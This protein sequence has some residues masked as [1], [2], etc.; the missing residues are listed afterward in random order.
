[1]KRIAII[2]L[3]AL[4][5]GCATDQPDKKNHT[6]TRIGFL[7]ESVMQH[8]ISLPSLVETQSGKITIRQLEQFY[9]DIGERANPAYQIVVTYRPGMKIPSERGRKIEL[10]GTVS[11][12]DVGGPPGTK[13]EYK[14]EAL[15]LHSWKYLE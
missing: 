14:N 5:T 4:L 6:V 12:I 2:L 9:F 3:A 15:T 1:M 13:G 7:A 10:T 8:P 11:T